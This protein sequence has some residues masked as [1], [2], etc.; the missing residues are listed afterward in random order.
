MKEKLYTIPV[1]EAFDANTECPI[2]FIK[3]KLE[4]DAIEYTMGTSYMEDFVRMETDKDGFC[5]HHLP[6]LY[7]NQNRLGLA[8]MLKTHM[9]KTIKD[10]EKLAGSSKKLSSP[11]LF[12]KKTTS[13]QE[14]KQY[15]DRL[16][17]SCFV[18][19]RVNGF[20]ERYIA[21]IFYIYQSD[22]DFRE[23]FRKGKGFCTTHYGLLYE[24]A[25]KQ[26]N[27][28]MVENFIND[29]NTLYIENLKRV[30]DDLDWFID[31]FDY[32]YAN[33]PWKNSKD[34]LIRS[35]LK[36]NGIVEES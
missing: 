23:K 2:C 27:A 33:E 22:M 12:K 28:S 16:D 13:S 5:S 26:L 30:R 14:V 15:V 35:M 29:I 20:F 10:I 19:K 17:S 21:T 31:K 3:N 36:V 6:L 18:C 34:A 7:K 4:V 25:T 8:L 24:E 11:S 1:N 9:D 32:R